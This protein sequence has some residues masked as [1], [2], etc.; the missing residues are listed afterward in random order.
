LTK[1]KTKN[2]HIQIDWAKWVDEDEEEE[3]PMGNEWD[4]SQ[5]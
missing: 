4:P 5:M 1:D 2:P 3:K